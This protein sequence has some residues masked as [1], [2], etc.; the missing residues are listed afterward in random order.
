MCNLKAQ[1]ALKLLRIVRSVKLC[2]YCLLRFRALQRLQKLMGNIA[3]CLPIVFKLAIVLFMISYSYAILGMEIFHS[4]LAIHE[5]SPY[6]EEH[7]SNFD[8]L[9]SALLTLFHVVNGAQ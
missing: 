4:D 5:E 9:G 7:Y 2:K 8:N 3:I 6:V 1:R